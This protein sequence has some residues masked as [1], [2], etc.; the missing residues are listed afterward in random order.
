M[1]APNQ[2]QTRFSTL[3]RLAR[4]NKIYWIIPLVLTLLLALLVIFG[5]QSKAPFVYTLF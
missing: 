4:Q 1:T 3:L 5:S 2:T